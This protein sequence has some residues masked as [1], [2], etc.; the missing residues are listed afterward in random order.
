MTDKYEELVAVKEKIYPYLKGNHMKWIS[1]YYD[2]EQYF[3]VLDIVKEVVLTV[4]RK[5]EGT[6]AVINISNITNVEYDPSRA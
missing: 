1:F 5:Q 2:G 4:N 6:I 3:G